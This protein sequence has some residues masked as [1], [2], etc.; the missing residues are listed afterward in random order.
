M[1]WPGFV[2]LMAACGAGLLGMWAGPI[3]LTAARASDHVYGFWAGVVYT[4]VACKWYPAR[5]ASPAPGTT[6]P[7]LKHGSAA[8]ADQ[9]TCPD[10]AG[11][12]EGE[13]CVHC[14][15]GIEHRCHGQGG[16][17]FTP[18]APEEG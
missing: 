1:S 11:T 2:L 16:H 13:R 14:G 12:T 10:H 18:A 9:A 4:L 6:E 5:P 7:L 17:I 3:G 8:C 15:R